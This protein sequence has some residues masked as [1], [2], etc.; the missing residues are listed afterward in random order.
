MNPY[1]FFICINSETARK[2][3]IQDEDEIVLESV[4]GKKITGRAR[5][6][7]IIHPEGLAIASGLGGHWTKGQ[8]IALGKGIYFNELLELDLDHYDP[9]SLNMD[10]TVQV[11]VYKKER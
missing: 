5:L 1:S 3:G 7:E 8:P 11:K 10:V 6:T 4:K 2:K 9:A